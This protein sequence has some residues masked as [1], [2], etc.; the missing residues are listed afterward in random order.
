MAGART[1]SVVLLAFHYPP[2]LGAASERAASFARHLPAMGWEPIVVTVAHGLYHRSPGYAGPPVTTVRTRSPEPSRLLPRGDR[3]A[4]LGPAMVPDRTLGSGGS[5]LR[6]FV[7]DYLYLPDAQ[8][9][10][11]PFAVAGLRRALSYASAAPVVLSTSVPYSAHLAAAWLTRRTG[12]PW[13]AELRDPWMHVHPAIRRRPRIRRR[14]DAA[15]ER[16]VVESASA[17]VVT[18]EATRQAM[19]RRYPA[20]RHRARVVM[21]GFE[22]LEHTPASPPAPDGP[23][24]LV[25][26]GTV[27]AHAPIEPLLHGI[28]AAAGRRPGQIRLTVLGQPGRWTRAASSMGRPAWL[29]VRGLVAPPAA[30]LAAARA[31]ANLLICPGVEYDEHVAAKLMEYLGVRR[32]VLAIISTSGEMAALGRDY[33]DLRVVPRF[34]AA[35]VQAAVERLLSDHRRGLLRQ[36]VV[37]SRPVD[38]LSR[39]AQARRLAEALHFALGR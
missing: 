7:R 36:A 37:P 31:S 11:I 14:I 39:E 28:D 27:P 30:R 15:L 34:T 23:L 8:V 12:L 18:S 35:E 4:A 16:R 24:E 6:R 1:G 32:P 22:P 38:E 20:L 17:V 29:D 2:M 3:S 10:W 13:V 19:V 33:G 26:A 25:H 9:L 21:N 5:R